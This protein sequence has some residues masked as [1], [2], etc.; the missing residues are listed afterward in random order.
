MSYGLR[1]YAGIVSDF[2]TLRLD[3]FCSEL[4]VQCRH[5]SYVIAVRLWK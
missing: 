4:C 2:T 5:R 1:D 3:Q